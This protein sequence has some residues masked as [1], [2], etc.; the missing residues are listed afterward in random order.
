M[1]E[2][3]S[4]KTRRAASPHGRGV[5]A[6]DCDW[7]LALWQTLYRSDDRGRITHSEAVQWGR[8]PIF[9]LGRT[10]HGNLW[11]VADGVPA[12]VAIR[13]ARLAAREAVL[14]KEGPPWPPCERLGAI[15]AALGPG[16]RTQE[17]FQVIGFRLPAVENH[18]FEDQL[19]RPLGSTL[20]DPFNENP[21]WIRSESEAEGAQTL[22]R[23]VSMEGDEIASFCEPVVGAPFSFTIA[24]VETQLQWRRR[25][26]AARVLKGWLRGV[27]HAGG[28]PIFFADATRPEARALATSVGLEAFVALTFWF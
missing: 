28:T 18:D 11:R 17:D 24:Y 3:S 22:K 27:R 1:K 14:G 6:S 25:G 13:S 19:T 12:T 4:R 5:L 10:R 21:G 7:L 16:S 9:Q 20:R 8:V 26:H 23:E 2:F 15:R